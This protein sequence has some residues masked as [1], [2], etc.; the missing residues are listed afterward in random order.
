MFS[1]T[2]RNLEF[3]SVNDH[4]IRRFNNYRSE[5][6]MKINALYLHEQE[7]QFID[8]RKYNQLKK[9]GLYTYA[10]YITST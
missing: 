7:Y 5:R 3:F 8:I 6:L 9:I 1:S 4:I 10:T 2:I